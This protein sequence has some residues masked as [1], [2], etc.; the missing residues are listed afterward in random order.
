MVFTAGQ[1][2]SMPEGFTGIRVTNLKGEL[3]WDVKRTGPVDLRLPADL[4]AG[5]LFVHYAK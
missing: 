4:G 2:V 1:T 3:V 5:V